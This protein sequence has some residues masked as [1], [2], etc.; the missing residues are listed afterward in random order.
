MSRSDKAREIARLWSERPDL[1]R[2]EGRDWVIKSDQLNAEI[3]KEFFE[4]CYSI[5]IPYEELPKEIDWFTESCAIYPKVDKLAF[6]PLYN[7]ANT[8]DGCPCS[9]HWKNANKK[10]NNEA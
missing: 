9:T 10:N 3:G 5:A 6:N 7:E 2:I 4:E 8:G 1:W